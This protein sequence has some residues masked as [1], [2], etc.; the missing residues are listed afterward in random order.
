MKFKPGTFAKDEDFG[1]L[2]ILS[3]KK[4]DLIKVLFLDGTES[5]DEDGCIYTDYI[6]PFI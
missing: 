5:E 3:Y 1:L 6:T 4:E 2:I